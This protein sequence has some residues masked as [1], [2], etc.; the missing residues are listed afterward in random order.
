MHPRKGSTWEA[1]ADILVGFEFASLSGEFEPGLE[2]VHRES[3]L[4]VGVKANELKAAPLC[5]CAGS[6]LDMGNVS[7]LYS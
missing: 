7:R 5:T 4:F 1:R 2:L 3:P 6:R